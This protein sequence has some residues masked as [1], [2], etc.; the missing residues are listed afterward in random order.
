MIKALI[1]DDEQHC[2]EA[3]ELLVKKYC[4]DIELLDSCKDALCG[5]DTIT[6]HQPDVVFL[7][8]AMPKIDGFEMLN[9]MDKIDFEIIFTTAYDQYAIKAFKVSAVDYL[10]KPIDRK[11]LVEATKKVKE[12]I[13]LKSGVP[14]EINKQVEHLLQTIQP[15]QTPLQQISIPTLTGLEMIKVDDILYVTGDGNYTNI[16]VKNKSHYMIS[17]T[18][19]FVENKLL[20]YPFFF[21]IHN[22]SLINLNEMKR[23]VRGKSGY[24]IMSD[25]KSLNVAR[26]RKKS[27]LEKLEYYK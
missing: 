19:K 24:V 14:L 2:I 20:E 27:F 9:R 1:V 3:L 16:I 22:S 12:R 11:E 8:I 13:I 7:D 6:K 23:Y 10:L 25:G 5:I 4:T 21:R 26:H 17:K 15:P 18:I